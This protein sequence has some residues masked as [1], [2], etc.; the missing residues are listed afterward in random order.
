MK[1]LESL[2]SQFSLFKVGDKTKVSI[3]TLNDN[4]GA[5]VKTLGGCIGNIANIPTDT[6]A[7]AIIEVIVTDVKEGIPVFE[8]TPEYMLTS[9]PQEAKVCF[10]G[11][12]A[13][14]MEF[15]MVS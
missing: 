13:I 9:L 10:S 3:I 12:R 4:G 8:M 6:Y 2:Q 7:G 11:P 15:C 1:S 5:K 14:V